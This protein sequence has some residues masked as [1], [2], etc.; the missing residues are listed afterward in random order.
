MRVPVPVSACAMGSLRQL[1]RIGMWGV[2]EGTESSRTVSRR[3]WICLGKKCHCSKTSRQPLAGQRAPD[4]SLSPTLQNEL[5]SSPCRPFRAL[6]YWGQLL[7]GLQSYFLSPRH[8][9]PKKHSLWIWILEVCYGGGKQGELGSRSLPA[10]SPCL[11][12]ELRHGLL[13][14]NNYGKEKMQS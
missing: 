8:L 9:L 3:F 14:T 2:L 7:K 1:R 12:G 4:C 11:S 6:W 13:I 5:L 10:F